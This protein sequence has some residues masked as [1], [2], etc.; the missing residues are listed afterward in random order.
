M[1]LVEVVDQASINFNMKYCVILISVLISLSS[2]CIS[3][4]SNLGRELIDK[5]SDSNCGDT[6]QIESSVFERWDSLYV[7]YDSFNI[8]H[9][10]WGNYNTMSQN[11]EVDFGMLKDLCNNNSYS[12]LALISKA[13]VGMLISVPIEQFEFIDPYRKRKGELSFYLAGY[14]NTKFYPIKDNRILIYKSCENG[15]LTIVDAD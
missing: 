11:L 6:I 13:K 15:Y 14:H 1:Q 2:C 5:I 4:S 3:D 12:Y 9:T 7:V 10:G 8:K